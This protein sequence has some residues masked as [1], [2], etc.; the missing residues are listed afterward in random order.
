MRFF[1][2]D[3][4]IKGLL[5]DAFGSKASQQSPQPYQPRNP[6]AASAWERHTGISEEDTVEILAKDLPH[7]ISIHLQFKEDENRGVIRMIDTAG[8][9]EIELRS[10]NMNTMTAAPGDIKVIDQGQGVGRKILRNELEFFAACGIQK[11]QIYASSEAGGYVWARFGFL[12]SNPKTGEL[13]EDLEWRFGLIEPLLNPDE[14]KQLKK[15]IELKKPQDL[16]QLADMRVNMTPRLGNIANKTLQQLCDRLELPAIMPLGRLLLT[17]SNWD[18]YIDLKN[19]EQMARV[20]RYVGGWGSFL[21]KE[22]AED[23]KEKGPGFLQGL[24]KRNI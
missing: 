15:L 13:K 20:E 17:G 21:K 23:L 11:F 7:G 3:I 9:V 24:L 1:G 14:A 8:P 12:P 19:K 18:G 22:P 4:T 6:L 10:F 2:T 16:W 5:S